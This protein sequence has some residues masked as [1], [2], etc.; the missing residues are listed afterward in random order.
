MELGKTENIEIIFIH[1]DDLEVAIKGGTS[2]ET[3]PFVAPDQLE[4]N[5]TI[6]CASAFLPSVRGRAEMVSEGTFA[7]KF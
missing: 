4:S 7:G 6:T 5:V 3:P 1:T 2:G